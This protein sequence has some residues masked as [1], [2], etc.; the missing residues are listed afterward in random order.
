[1]RGG[2]SLVIYRC[3]HCNNMHY[4]YNHNIYSTP[5]YFVTPQY[6]YHLYPYPN[7]TEL[8]YRDPCE[9]QQG[10]NTEWSATIYHDEPEL[11][12]TAE[13]RMKLLLDKPF[14]YRWA[15]RGGQ[16]WGANWKRKAVNNAT[17]QIR[18]SIA[19]MVNLKQLEVFT[20]SDL[21]SL[22][23]VSA[24]KGK[25]SALVKIGWA[26]DK[27]TTE[28][29]NWVNQNNLLIDVRDV[30]IVPGTEWIHKNW[31]GSH[32]WKVSAT[33]QYSLRIYGNV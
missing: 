20:K 33:M 13:R 2:D 6:Y 29:V 27:S 7:S 24:T 25:D 1:M 14:T 3:L 32:T 5:N 10:T 19:K 15:Y 16:S 17:E 30:E 21:K 22:L 18:T 9:Y 23:D 11:R 8:L 28:Q 4:F 26:E 31:L 12:I